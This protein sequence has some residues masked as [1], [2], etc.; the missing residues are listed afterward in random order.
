MK[1]CTQ[2]VLLTFPGGRQFVCLENIQ[3]NH[4]RIYFLNLFNENLLYY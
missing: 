1:W 3:E 4:N 2:K